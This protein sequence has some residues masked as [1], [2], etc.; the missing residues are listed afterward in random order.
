MKRSVFGIFFII[1]LFSM[2]FISAVPPITSE[3][4]GNTGLDIEAN[5][6]DYYKVNEGAEI[7]IYVFNIT[8]GSLVNTSEVTCSVELTDSNGTVKLEGT[9]TPDGDHYHMIRPASVVTKAGI[10]AV[11]VVC[12]DS[13]I[14]GY[15]TAF[16]EANTKGRSLSIPR[17]INYTLAMLFFIGLMMGF[18]IVS[19]KIN[20]D[21]WYNSIVAKYSKTNGLKV[22]LSSI[23]YNF[24]KETFITYYLLFFPVI[25]L[26]R[27]MMDEFGII[28]IAGIIDSMLIIY[29]IGLVIV[30]LLFFGKIQEFVMK[31]IDQIKDT[32]WG[33]GK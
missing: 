27:E 22:A 28:S 15:K 32:K 9:A 12:N 16:F 20:Y 11:T 31:L 6:Q 7:H 13:S 19:S 30:G 18:Y 2:A 25:I 29:S 26:F 10:Y 17:V 33:I 23:T 1:M 3:F 24:A 4:T 21:K 14:A 5:F 8:T